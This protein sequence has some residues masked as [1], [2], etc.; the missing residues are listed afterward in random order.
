MPYQTILFETDGAVGIVNDEVKH[1]PFF[2]LRKR[3]DKDSDGVEQRDFEGRIEPLLAGEIGGKRG[4]GRVLG[5]RD[6]DRS[7]QDRL[8]GGLARQRRAQ[9]RRR[10]VALSRRR[11]R[12]AALRQAFST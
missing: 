11:R 10:L 8:G 7:D 4:G 6:A 2:M 1:M 3:D 5:R 12:Q 9:R